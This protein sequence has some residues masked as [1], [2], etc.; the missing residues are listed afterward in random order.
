MAQNRWPRLALRAKLAALAVSSNPGSADF[1]RLLV[2]VL[3]HTDPHVVLSFERSE[4]R[5]TVDVGDE[6][7]CE[8]FATGGYEAEEIASLL[9]WV[10]AHRPAGHFPVALDAGANVGTTSIPLARAGYRVIAIEPVARTASMLERNVADNGLDG[11]IDV[12]RAAIVESDH[13]V[14]MVRSRGSGQSELAS[15]GRGYGFDRWGFGDWGS[16]KVPGRRLESVVDEAGVDADDIA[17][18]WSDVQGAEEGVVRSG[19]KLWAAGAPLW[20]E[21][22]PY[23]IERH[24]GAEGFFSAVEEHFGAFLTLQAVVRD[25]P[26]IPLRHFREWAATIPSFSDALLLPA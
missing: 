1:R 5:W 26:P 15:A 9:G 21:V 3:W 11:G 14:E 16:E 24:G 13:E 20:Q 17:F 22:W 12:V 10:Q 7:G 23:A 25:E 6:I 8:L 18:V 19:A 2:D 4:T